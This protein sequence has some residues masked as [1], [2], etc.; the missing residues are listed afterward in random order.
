MKPP[1]PAPS[2]APSDPPSEVPSSRAVLCSK[3]EHLNPRGSHRCEA[4][5]SHL[6]LSC[7]ACGTHNERTRTRCRQCGRGL[8]R[9]LASQVRSQ[10]RKRRIVVTRT[11]VILFFLGLGIVLA[12]LFTRLW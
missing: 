7:R 8:H 4:C 2:P 5:G 3:C 9:T 12:F 10:L 6:Y 11:H 1:E